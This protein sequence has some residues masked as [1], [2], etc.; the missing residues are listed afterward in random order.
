MMGDLLTL[1]MLIVASAGMVIAVNCDE[2]LGI[3]VIV[4]GGGSILAIG[5]IVSALNNGAHDTHV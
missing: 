3:G 1:A 5:Y 2:L 4:A